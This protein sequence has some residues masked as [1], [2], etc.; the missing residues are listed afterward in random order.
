MQRFEKWKQVVY[1]TG[2]GGFSILDNIFG[3]YFMFFLLPPKETGLPELISNEP[4]FM[5]LTI[6]GLIIIFGRVIDSIADPL[7]AYWSDRNKSRLG[8]R[9]FF[10]LTG[11]LPFALFS[12]LLFILPD[13]HTSTANAIYTAVILGLYFFFY[14]Y[15][16]APYLALIPE[17]THTHSDRIFLTVIQA[18][19]MLIGAGIVMMGVPQIWKVI[20]SSGV[21]KSDSF[22]YSIGI[23]AAL[24]FIIAFVA[25][26]V[27]D[28]KKYTKGEPA[29]V[30]LFES[31]KMTL[32]NKVFIFYMLPVILY[33]FTF[34]MIRST[35][36]YYPVVLL[37]KESDFQTILTVEL[38][39]GAAIFFLLISF[40][41][42]K[43]SN[44]GFMSSGLLSFS[45]LLIITFFINQFG[46]YAV[47]VAGIQMFLMG[48]PVAVLMVIPNAIVSDI[49]EVDGY[50]TGIK[51][52]AMF[53]GTQGL[54]MK[55]NYGIAA[56]IIAGL[57]S[58]FGKDLAN[59]LGV[60]LSGPV[61]AVFA[62]TGF[63][64]FFAYPQEWV[65]EK[66]KEIR[67]NKD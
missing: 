57:F 60:K 59:P 43:V 7:I 4:M 6:I 44:K 52:E 41:S 11:A 30:P 46:E 31:I 18:F 55:V 28:E 36:A 37:G 14:T 23:V 19:F 67:N 15:Y 27:V 9:R 39:G 33:W 13:N 53:F 17:L 48:Y 20:E 1:G 2:N 32:K 22:V 12:L 24:G 16:M 25:G 61:A 63:L 65:S 56:A 49:A 5:G 51:R 54:F 40:L 47:L 50:T 45:L 21:N 34:H 38:F 42:K 62:F 8:R 66:L 29:E 26:F 35:L 3:I 10:L 58:I 64:I